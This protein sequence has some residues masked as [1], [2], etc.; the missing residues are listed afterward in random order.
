MQQHELLD[1]LHFVVQGQLH[2]LEDFGHHAG[3]FVFVSVKRPAVV[4]LE[5][6][7]SWLGDVMQNRGPTQPKVVGDFRHVIQYFQ[8]MV[9]VVFVTNSVS[10]LHAF[11]SLHLREYDA[12]QSAF[13]EQLESN[14]RPWAQDDLVQLGVDALLADDLHAV[15]IPLN[16]CD[17]GIGDAEVQLGC[18]PNRPQ[19]AQWVVTERDVRVQ[20]RLDAFIL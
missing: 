15:G 17:V 9:E 18:E 10:P 13:V 5:P 14:R 20:W 7:G 6:F 2:A 1:K 8:R 4:P 16:G 11:E 12:Q 3:A 19:H